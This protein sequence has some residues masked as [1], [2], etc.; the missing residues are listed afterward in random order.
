MT[1]EAGYRQPLAA[2]RRLAEGERDRRSPK[3]RLPDDPAT[4]AESYEARRFGPGP[5]HGGSR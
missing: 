5:T 1:T 4:L 2:M 3:G